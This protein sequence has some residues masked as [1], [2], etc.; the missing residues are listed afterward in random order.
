MLTILDN[1]VH[2]KDISMVEESIPTFETYCKHLDASSW[3]SDKERSS[4]F[5]KIVQTYTTFASREPIP[6]LKVPPSPPVAIR[7]RTA[8]LKAVRSVVGSDAFGAE[9]GTQLSIVMP[10]IL[11]NLYSDADDILASLQKRAQSGEKI[12]VEKARQRRM[13]IATVTTVDTVDTNPVTATGTTADADKEAEDE[14][15]TLAVRCLKQVFAAGTGSNRG[16]IRLAT[17]LT[18]KFIATKN[19]PAMTVAQTSSRSGKRGN[20]ATS[21]IEAVARWTPVQD[22]F[23]IVVTAMETLIRSPITETVLDKQLAL[24]TMIDWLLSSSINLIGLSVMDVLLG[25]VQ[26][27]LL[28]LQ[29]GGRD[30]K[31]T[32]H[33]QQSEALDLY[34][35]A[36]ETFES[37]SPFN[38]GERGRGQSTDEATP[39]P[40]RQELLL[41][42]QKCIGDLATHIYYTDQISDM[43]TAILARLKPSLQS[44][45]S[46]TTAAIDDPVAAVRAIAKS[47]SLQED[48]TTDGFFSFA[49]ARVT[50]LRAIKDILIIANLRKSTTGAAAESRSRVGVQVWEGTQWLLRDEDREVRAAYVDALL[51]WLKLETNRN[52]THLPKDGPR[53]SRPTKK[54]GADNEEIRIAKRAASNASRRENRPAKSTFVQL[55]H[56]AM[57]DNALE[58]PENDADIMLLHLLLATL[59]DR[60]GVNAVQPGLPMIFRLQEVA[61]NNELDDV[62]RAKVNIASLVHGY[63]WALSEKFDFETTRVGSE[64]NLEISRRKKNT[65]WLGKLTFPPLTVEKIVTASHLSEKTDVIHENAIGSIKPYLNRL[66]L[67]LE[68]ANAYDNSLVT[69]PTSPPT[70]PGRV[71]S[72]PT[73]GFGY[74]YGISPGPRPSPEH[75]MPQKVKDEMLGDWSREGCIAAVEQ[76]STKT[77]SV[78][79]SRTGASSG[80]RNHLTVNGG[81]VGNSDSDADMPSAAHNDRV[82]GESPSYGLV[83]GLANLQNKRRPS[84]N[85]SPGHLTLSSSHESVVRVTDL[86]RALSGYDARGRHASPLRRPMSGLDSVLDSQHSV[87]DSDSMVSYN[88]VDGVDGSA[89]DLSGPAGG[90]TGLPSIAGTQEPTTLASSLPR[91]QKSPVATHPQ[92]VHDLVSLPRFNSDLRLGNDIPPVPQIPSVMNLPGTYPVDGSPVQKGGPEFE[93]F[94]P[95]TAPQGLQNRRLN[96]SPSS[97]SLREGRGLKRGNIPPASRREQAATDPT[98][99]GMGGSKINLGRLLAGIQ[100]SSELDAS[101]VKGNSGTGISRPP[102]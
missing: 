53:K 87:T 16:Q 33:H 37:G 21:L 27:T 101:G 36:N 17:T 1:V 31:V 45:V 85:G 84:T 61:L 94:R 66:D 50:A 89:L 71:F 47:A 2:S 73:L 41:R 52:D 57:Y 93:P 69:P 55:L 63:L 44:N 88:E 54:A 100:V 30:S 64:I 98:S 39:S 48:P 59:V 14:V 18:L 7:W 26:H 15:R 65:L 76:E 80:P 83:G 11:E 8:G 62:P 42:L 32:P 24:A 4:Q 49:T 28:L 81:V 99:G 78:S 77:A 13:S 60:L 58:T 19:P 6:D 38:D 35:D 68:I 91:E 34:R 40:V 72:V 5:L 102:Y 86:K 46:S 97:P 29:L 74:G 22:R 20:W 10:V 70:S 82:K 90:A 56:L 96:G 43:M 25:F 67:V 23:I 12:D 92:T 79:G 75:Q 9:S 3:A 51:T 95:Q